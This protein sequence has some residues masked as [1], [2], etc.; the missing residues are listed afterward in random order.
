[1]NHPQSCPVYLTNVIRNREEVIQ[2]SITL[3]QGGYSDSLKNIAL[4]YKY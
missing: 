3:L 1:M 4:N 2:R